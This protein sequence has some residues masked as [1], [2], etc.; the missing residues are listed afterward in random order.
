M[1]NSAQSTIVSEIEAL[2][3]LEHKDTII[4]LSA[5][6][7]SVF[8]A[9]VGSR[10]TPSTDVVV[11]TVW[12]A[13]ILPFIVIFPMY[14]ARKLWGGEFG[15]VMSL[16]LIGVAMR[17]AVQAGNL[18]WLFSG[19]PAWFNVSPGTWFLLFHGASLVGFATIAYGF[20][21][22]WNVGENKE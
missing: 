18:Q 22:L 4:V 2:Y 13:T 9:A 3:K 21:L 12:I 19:T 7:L 17:V 11:Y 15:R 20:Y 6:L 1:T 8:T 10:V 5:V 16:I 14:R